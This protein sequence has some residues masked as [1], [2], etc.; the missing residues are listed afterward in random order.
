LTEPIPTPAPRSRAA[1]VVI[2][3]VAWTAGTVLGTPGSTRAAR[4]QP[5]F[6]LNQAHAGYVPVLDGSEP[7]FILFLGSDARPGEQITGQRSDSIHLVGINPEKKKASILGFPRDSWV[8]IPGYGTNKIN[9]AMTE[10][11]PDLVVKT[12][13]SLTGIT[14]DYWTLTWFEGFQ[15]M[16]NG[17]G[18]LTVDV[19]FAM[20]DSYSHAYFDPGVQT[21]NGRDALAFARNRHDLPQGDFG[22]S[23]D[24]GLLMVS[25][26]TQFKREFSKDPARLFD[27]VGAGLRNVRTDVPLDQVMN[28]AFTAS[29]LNAKKVQNMVVPGSTGMAGNESIVNLD[30][31]ALQAI[32]ND[33]KPD[34]IV[35]P[36]NVPPSPNASLTS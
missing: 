35:S 24:Q 14:I 21:L 6:E 16:V 29:V 27:W 23:E 33:M 1:L 7:I 36:K 8:S 20:S 3:L 25:A 18:G 12:V 15:A 17:I 13:E 31:A 30:Q 32:A 4:A 9:A 34:G 26:L 22:R 5:L 11:G 28:L 19:P 10:G 2:L